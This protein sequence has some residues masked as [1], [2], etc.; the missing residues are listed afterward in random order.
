WDRTQSQ[1]ARSVSQIRA[2]AGRLPQAAFGRRAVSEDVGVELPGVGLVLQ[3]DFLIFDLKKVQVLRAN[4]I[5]KILKKIKFGPRKFR[6][7]PWV[8]RPP[9]DAR[10]RGRRAGS[11]GR[12]MPFGQ[13]PV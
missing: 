4:L 5:S 6:R 7:D 9:R 11:A 1:D 12:A 13:F 10:T 2:R 3:L 8:A